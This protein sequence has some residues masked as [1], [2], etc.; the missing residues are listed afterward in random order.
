MRRRRYAEAEQNLRHAL[1]LSPGE[2]TYRL[3]LAVVLLDEHKTK[4]GMK[5][6]TALS[7]SADIDLARQATQ[8]L[9][10]AGSLRGSDSEDPDDEI[11]P[12]PAAGTPAEP[13]RPESKK[14]DFDH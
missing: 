4:A 3:D 13:T 5:L 6:L 12:A 9:A 14:R 11:G 7:Q 2:E 10:S 8:I 1:E